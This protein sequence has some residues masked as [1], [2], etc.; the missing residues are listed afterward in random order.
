L[1]YCKNKQLSE[2]ILKHLAVKIAYY[3][4]NSNPNFI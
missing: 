2:N 3:Q 4:L 1:L